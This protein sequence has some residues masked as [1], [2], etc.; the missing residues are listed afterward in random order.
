[1]ESIANR[2]FTAISPCQ[3]SGSTSAKTFSSDRLVEQDCIGELRRNIL[4]HSVMKSR[5]N[6]PRPAFIRTGSASAIKLAPLASHDFAGRGL[7]QIGNKLDELGHLVS[8]EFLATES[9]DTFSVACCT[10]FKTTY[11]LAISPLKSSG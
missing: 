2:R 3:S 10:G 5:T 8:S 7:W 11:A 4:S 9:G 6:A 1:M